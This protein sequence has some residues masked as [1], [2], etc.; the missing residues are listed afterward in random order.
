MSVT[1]RWQ[2]SRREGPQCDGVRRPNSVPVVGGHLGEDGVHE[3]GAGPADEWFGGACGGRNG[4]DGHGLSALCCHKE[5][6]GGGESESPL[7]PAFPRLLAWAG[8]E[9]HGGELL[10]SQVEDPDDV[11]AVGDQDAVAVRT[12]GR[13]TDDVNTC[14]L[15]TSDAADD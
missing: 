14:L 7:C 2:L 9:R 10:G 4:G 15:Y 6:V 12:P 3:L 8:Q 13:R 11:V 1:P 5:A